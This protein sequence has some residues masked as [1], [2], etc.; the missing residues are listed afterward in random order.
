MRR[1]VITIVIVVSLSIVAF[2]QQN[3]V[4]VPCRD[5][6][7][8][9]TLWNTIPT[10]EG[11]QFDRLKELQASLIADPPAFTHSLDR[12]QL[13]EDLASSSDKLTKIYRE[14]LAIERK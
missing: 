14:M 13:L 2:T 10:I 12:E 7:K 4:T 1:T 3:S 9:L 8:I 6:C 11:E 5:K